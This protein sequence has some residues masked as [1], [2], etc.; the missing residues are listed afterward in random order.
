MTNGNFNRTFVEFP[1]VDWNEYI[2]VSRLDLGGL[3]TKKLCNVKIFMT[4]WIASEKEKFDVVWNDAIHIFRK[5][6]YLYFIFYIKYK[7]TNIKLLL[8]WLDLIL[9]KCRC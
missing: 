2:L 7:N 3:S 8:K 9:L 1:P 5:I 6:S 4:N